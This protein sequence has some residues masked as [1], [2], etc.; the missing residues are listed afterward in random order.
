MEV[1]GSWREYA[2]LRGDTSGSA[3]IPLAPRGYAWLHGDTPGSVGIPL[4][5]WGYAWLHGD[6]S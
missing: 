3:G 4:A 6:E 1:S 2:W 5:P